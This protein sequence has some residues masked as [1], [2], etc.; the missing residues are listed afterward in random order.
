MR[1]RVLVFVGALAVFLLV[2]ATV[3]TIESVA[4]SRGI[5]AL[6]F[7]L[8]SVI[9]LGSGMLYFDVPHHLAGSR[10]AAAAMLLTGIASVLFGFLGLEGRN[11]VGGQTVEVVGAVLSLIALLLVTIGPRVWHR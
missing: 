8:A 4:G 7:G 11:S 9:L 6:F 3:A 2:G 5:A 1:S 10:A